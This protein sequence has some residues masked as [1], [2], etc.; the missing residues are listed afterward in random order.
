MHYLTLLNHNQIKVEGKNEKTN[1][2]YINRDNVLDVTHYSKLIF[3]HFF[4]VLDGQEFMIAM[5]ALN[6]AVFKI[7]YELENGDEQ[8]IV[9]RCKT[10][11][12][13][14]ESMIETMR[15]MKGMK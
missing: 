3:D 2:G 4:E 7:I 13:G 8:M 1:R 15:K 5:S 12:G 9:R 14:F 11:Y 10:F 6:M